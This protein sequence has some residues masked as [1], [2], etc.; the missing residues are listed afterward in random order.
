[1]YRERRDNKIDFS[2]L[3][4]KKIKN[5]TLQNSLSS[6][7]FMGPPIPHFREP[8]LNLE[9]V[10]Y[11]K[12][13]GKPNRNLACKPFY[14]AGSTFLRKQVPQLLMICRYYFLWFFRSVR[15]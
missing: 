11:W 1:M 12:A 4:I 8:D 7:G 5:S 15:R 13:T 9:P 2:T 14:K 6:F 10:S 3:S